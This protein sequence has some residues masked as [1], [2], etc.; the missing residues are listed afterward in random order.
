MNYDV[1]FSYYS[2][3]KGRFEE[4]GYRVNAADQFEARQKAWDLVDSDS[5]RKYM[6]CLRQAGVTWD[7]SPVNI[8]EYLIAA[9]SDCKYQ[10]K[11]AENVA[12]PN[13]A[14]LGNADLK[15][16]ARNELSYA[17]G[18]LDFL[19]DISKD[20]CKPLKMP[21]PAISD[22]LHYAERLV[23]ESERAGNYGHV[24]ALAKEIEAAKEW[25]HYSMVDLQNLFKYGSIYLN[26]QFVSYAAHFSKDGVFP[27]KADLNDSEYDYIWRWTGMSR[28]NRLSQLPMFGQKDVITGS[29]NPNSNISDEF[30][31]FVINPK[32]LPDDMRIPENMLWTFVK[33]EDDF[34][35]YAK[36]KITNEYRDL[37]RDD[38]FGMLRPEYERNIDFH[39]LTKEYES[40]HDKP[41]EDY[42][43]P[44]EYE[45]E[46]EADDSFDDEYF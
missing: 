20:L 33:E 34:D 8:Q 1:R 41:H 5:N 31:V 7:A 18:K 42:R 15:E 38:F 28:V 19:S 16:S 27:E 36:N 13:A 2:E 46:Y 21:P 11:H 14:I 43:D 12:I 17:L 3:D 22:E 44:F 39:A 10:I 26:G 6:S 23:L 24:L 32:S 9:A 45:P 4:T 40:T 29:E 30:R 37:S 25:N 35:P